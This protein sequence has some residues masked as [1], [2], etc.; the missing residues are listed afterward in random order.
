ME[1]RFAGRVYKR[2]VRKPPA[3]LFYYGAQAEPQRDSGVAPQEAIYLNNRIQ[4][5]HVR[6]D[7]RSDR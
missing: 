3:I 6:R 4:L 7:G 1:V 2:P 5:K